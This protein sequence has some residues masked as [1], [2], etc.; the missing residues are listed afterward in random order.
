MNKVKTKLQTEIPTS[1]EWKCEPHSSF[2]YILLLERTYTYGIWVCLHHFRIH[3]LVSIVLQKSR[4]LDLFFFLLLASKE[5]DKPECCV[6]VIFIFLSDTCNAPNI[7][8]AANTVAK[9]PSPLSPLYYTFILQKKH[10]QQALV[11]VMLLRV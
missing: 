7:Q 5:I 11:Q 3:N 1:R 6:S 8:Q 10:E 2:K 9:A 4:G